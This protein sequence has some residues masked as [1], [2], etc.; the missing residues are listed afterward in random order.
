MIR[1]IRLIPTIAPIIVRPTGTRVVKP[2]E[3]AVSIG[4]ISSAVIE[5]SIFSP[6]CKIKE[7]FL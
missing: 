3:I 4:F 2:L 5:K 1:G 6:F 7:M